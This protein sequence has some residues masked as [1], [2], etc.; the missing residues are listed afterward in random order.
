[1]LSDCGYIGVT[2]PS[3]VGD[4]PN[5]WKK[6]EFGVKVH[7]M[8][9]SGPLDSGNQ[10]VIDGDRERCRKLERHGEIVRTYW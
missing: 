2:R 1:M 10:G 7:C 8:Q 5:K 3:K 6:V 9:Y 4:F